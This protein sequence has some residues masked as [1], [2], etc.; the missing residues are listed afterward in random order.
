[1]KITRQNGRG[2]IS[3]TFLHNSS[4][5]RCFAQITE[6][7]GKVFNITAIRHHLQ[8]RTANVC[9][10]RVLAQN[11]I[12]QVYDVDQNGYLVNSPAYSGSFPNSEP[13]EPGTKDCKL[14]LSLICFVNTTFHQR[15]QLS[16][17]DA[18]LDSLSLV[19]SLQL[20]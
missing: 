13:N 20:P 15:S 4:A 9:T 14:S 3:C 11:S 7:S 10:E 2:C 5:L 6:P 12:V 17:L 19:E 8:A 18:L 16:L 1:M